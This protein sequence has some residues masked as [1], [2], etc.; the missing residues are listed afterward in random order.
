[1]RERPLA[2]LAEQ[3]RL[4][5]HNTDSGLV[6]HDAD[7]YLVSANPAAELLLGLSLDDL[8][9]RPVLDARWATVGESGLPLAADDH[10]VIKALRTGQS[11]RGS[12]LGIHRPTDDG[13]GQ[14]RLARGRQRAALARGDR[15]ARTPWCPR[16][17]TS[18]AGQATDLALRE[19]EARYRLLADNSTD[20]ITRTSLKGVITWISPS[21]RRPAGLLAAGFDRRS[22]PR[23]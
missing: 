14:L 8:R 11:V 7:G 5:V 9:G 19:S 22:R 4:L 16:S 17:R 6:L 12:I 15:K 20:V 13:D 1:M 23:I 21:V 3:H 2:E 18:P 10:P